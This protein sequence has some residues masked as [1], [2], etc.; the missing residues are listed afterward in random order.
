VPDFV[1]QFGLAAVPKTFNQFRSA[2][3]DDPVL[4]EYSNDRGTITF[5]T[6][7]TNTR[8]SQLF[9]N[10]G[11][12]KFLDAK[13]FSPIGKVLGN[14]MSVI[15]RIQPKYCEEPSQEEIQNK[16]NV[17]LDDKFPLLSYFESWKTIVGRSYD[18]M[19]SDKCRCF[20][21]FLFFCVIFIIW[22]ANFMDTISGFLF[23]CIF[24]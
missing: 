15:D 6:S 13:G 20:D 21:T 3:K 17:Y 11:S 7:G 5:A 14:G 8:T 10:L 24:I 2:I 9:I 22:P 16:G 18:S 23:S 19:N 4:P 1:V 12:N